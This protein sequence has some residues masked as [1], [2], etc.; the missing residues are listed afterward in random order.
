MIIIVTFD[1]QKSVESYSADISQ[2]TDPKA[3]ISSAK[4]PDNNKR[5]NMHQNASQILRRRIN[6]LM[7]HIN[8]TSAVLTFVIIK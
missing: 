4:P 3:T 7:C 1:C 8:A 6:Y 2:Y 5:K